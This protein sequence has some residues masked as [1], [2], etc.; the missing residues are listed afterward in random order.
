MINA[1]MI[2]ISCGLPQGFLESFISDED[3]AS[4]LVS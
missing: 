1:N 4:Y 2:E 3:D